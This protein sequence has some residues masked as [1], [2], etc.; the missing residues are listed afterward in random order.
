[1]VN[2]LREGRHTV[3]P[4]LIASDVAGLVDFIRVVFDA[5]GDHVPDRPVEL[6]VGDSII[7]VS[8]GG[9]LRPS[10]PGMLYVYVADTDATFQSA[11]RAGAEI[12]E[13][14]TDMPWGDRRATVADSWGNIWQIATYL[15]A[16]R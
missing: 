12:I 16:G 1:M 13:P 7:M 14:P 9:G 10:M 15:G 2:Y 4:R 6:K 5:Q 11:T 3:T 8:D